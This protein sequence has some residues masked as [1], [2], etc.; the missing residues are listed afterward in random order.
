[1]LLAVRDNAILLQRRPPSGIWGGLWSF[2]Q[3][4]DLAELHEFA[5]AMGQ[6]DKDETERWLQVKH[7]FT[8]FDLEIT[9]VKIALKRASGRR[10]MDSDSS[11]WVDGELPGGC[12]A[13]V[14]RL[15]D[16]LTRTLL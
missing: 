8:H 11:C 12:A 15:L 3:F 6:Y 1:M 2:P 14:K 4:D 13:P 9:P 7:S 16:K 10:I 5:G